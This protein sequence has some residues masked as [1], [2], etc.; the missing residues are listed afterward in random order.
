MMLFC[1]SSK[2]D[3]D[4]LMHFISLMYNMYK[5]PI[6]SDKMFIVIFPTLAAT[7]L[8]IY[9]FCNFVTDIFKPDASLK[10]ATQYS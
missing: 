1:S 8:K 5:H 2:L 7:L 3:T 9:V 6:F 4:K 10:W